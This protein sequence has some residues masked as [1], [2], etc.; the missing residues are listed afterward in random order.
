MLLLLLLCVMVGPSAVVNDDCTVE[1]VDD[2]T[3]EHKSS[4]PSSRG[5]PPP[6]APVLVLLAPPLLAP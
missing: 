4:D 2:V 1:Y 5:D 3:I 6:Q